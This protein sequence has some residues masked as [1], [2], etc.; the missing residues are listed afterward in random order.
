M[1]KIVVISANLGNF[2]A[3]TEHVPQSI[4]ADYYRFTD[5]NFSPRKMAM[6]PRLQARIPKMFGWQMCQGYDYYIWIDSSLA[7]LHPDSIKWLL[8]Q[9]TGDIAFFIHPDRKTVAQ[10]AEFIKKRIETGSKYLCTRYT[11]ELIDEQL[12]EIQ[13]DNTYKDDLLL[14]TGSFIYKN[15]PKV[16]A[17]MKEWWYHTS[18]YHSVDQL[19]LPYAIYKT[20]CNVN[21]IKHELYD[22]TCSIRVI[23]EH[24][25]HTPY[26][27]YVRTR[28]R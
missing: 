10:E 14:A 12:A 8:E 23:K 2:D 27:T 16:H 22:S 17:L 3:V 19:G 18:R 13:A 6:T 11:N 25:M 5:E 7:M 28:N 21:V 15:N 24:Y 26:L 4:P 20:R 9:C 1:S